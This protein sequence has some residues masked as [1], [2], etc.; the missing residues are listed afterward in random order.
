MQD[1]IMR[2]GYPAL[3]LGS[4]LEGESALIAAGFLARSGY[5]D[6]VLVVLIALTGTYMADV[7]IYFLGR[8]K[9]K[10]II[11]K[12]PVA[13]FYYPRVKGLFDKYGIWALFITRYLYGFRLATA[14]FL[15]L[16]K[17]RKGRY[18]PFN[19]VSCTIW[20]I[21]VANLGYMFGASL[22]AL[23]GQVKHYEKVVVA[24]IIIAG[25]GTWL[26]RRVW[27]KRKSEKINQNT[28]RI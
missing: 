6:L 10:G 2:F 12:F 5:F 13:R 19:F 27:S 11:S 22:Q 28:M 3:F 26:I 23:M 8:K 17:V 4:L 16:M 20:A 9:G 1:F 18:L 7:S 14:G 15:G 25:V 24:L 21:L